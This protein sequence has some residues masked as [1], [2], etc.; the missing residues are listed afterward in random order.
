MLGAFYLSSITLKLCFQLPQ[1]LMWTNEIMRA[2]ST[3]TGINE[4][5]LAHHISLAS[6]VTYLFYI[7]FV[8]FE[9]VLGSRHSGKVSK[10]L[11]NKFYF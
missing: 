5:K 2:I 9:T 4:V 7:L 10:K 1:N 6:M 8:F 3:R 11:I